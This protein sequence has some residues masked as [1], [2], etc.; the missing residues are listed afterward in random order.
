MKCLRVTLLS[1]SLVSPGLLLSPLAASQQAQPE[2]QITNLDQLL[3]SVR[4]QQRQQRARSKQRE[5]QFLRDKQKQQALLEQAQSDEVFDFQ[6][7]CYK[8]VFDVFARLL[9]LPASPCPPPLRWTRGC[10]WW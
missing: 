10:W 8:L 7:L 2:Q 6:D 1:L 9:L 4:E 3:E 5:Q